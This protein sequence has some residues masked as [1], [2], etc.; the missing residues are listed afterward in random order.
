[1]LVFQRRV[2]ERIIIEDRTTGERIEIL[3]VDCKGGR[4]RIGVECSRERFAVDRE[5]I[6]IRRE[7]DAQQQP[8]TPA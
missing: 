6:L 5:E 8:P 1:M 3:L 4:S 7:R 2:D